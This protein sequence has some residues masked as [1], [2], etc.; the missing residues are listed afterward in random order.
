MNAMRVG[1]KKTIKMNNRQEII[2]AL[3]ILF[4]S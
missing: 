4:L 3:R 2:F 1:K